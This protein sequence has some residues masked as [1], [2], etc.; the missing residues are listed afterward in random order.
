MRE[1][2][3]VFDTAASALPLER[4]LMKGVIDEN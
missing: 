3:V 1:I 2:R 4:P